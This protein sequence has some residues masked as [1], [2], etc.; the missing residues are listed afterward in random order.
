[1]AMALEFGKG[2]SRLPTVKEMVIDQ[3]YTYEKP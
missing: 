2:Q 3:P 1:M